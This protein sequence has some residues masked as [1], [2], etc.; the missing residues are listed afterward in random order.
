MIL[1]SE[2]FIPTPSKNEGKMEQLDEMVIWSKTTLKD[3][4]IR[5]TWACL[6]PWDK[7]QFMKERRWGEC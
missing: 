1:Y 7:S 3:F 2:K 4:S 6:G 5:E